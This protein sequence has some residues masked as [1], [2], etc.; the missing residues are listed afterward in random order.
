MSTKVMKTEPDWLRADVVAP[1]IGVDREKRIILGYVV[2][3]EGP[4]REPEPRGEF[5]LKS[6]REIIRLMKAKSNGLK[7][8]F[9]H[10][11]LSSDA[12]GT[13]V[14]RA[15]DPRLDRATVDRD[16]G[17][18]SLM[19]VRA[20]LHLDK[21]A[22]ESNPN[23]NLGEYLLTVAESD[24]GLISSSLVLQV[25]E[26]WRL[27]KDGKPQANEDGTLLPP[28]WRPKVLHASDITDE[29]AAVDKLLSPNGVDLADAA[30]RQGSQL[31]DKLFSGQS[32]SVIEARCNAW[33]ARYLTMRFGGDDEPVPTPKL[34]ALRMRFKELAYQTERMVKV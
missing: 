31:L 22:F 4:F 20:D 21:S 15:R 23:G 24:N 2:A 29:G 17:H 13:A 5:D 28:L 1:R 16:G 11:S 30:V 6:L 7:S 33:L 14:G 8:R 12:A 34:D 9:G 19:A 18:V 10:P 25:D 3:Q 32:R 27:N 26:E